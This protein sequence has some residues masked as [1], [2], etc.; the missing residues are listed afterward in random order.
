MMRA[1]REKEIDLLG[2]IVRIGTARIYIRGR[3]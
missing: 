3:L 2:M 1:G